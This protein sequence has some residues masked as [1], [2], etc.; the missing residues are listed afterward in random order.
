MELF[1]RFMCPILNVKP[2]DWQARSCNPFRQEPV[3]RIPFLIIAL[4]FVVGST[5]R[6][7]TPSTPK[8]A[9]PATPRKSGSID[10]RDSVSLADV[11]RAANDLVIAV[12]QTVKKVT[13]NPELKVAALKLASSSVSAAQVVVAQ[14]AATLQAALDALSKEVAS[15]TVTE[16]RKIKTH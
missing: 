4:V 10:P 3:K 15:V 1:Q 9:A 14:Q 12:Q 16:Q 8:T 13:E 11:Q 5:A 6:A 7:Q 2:R